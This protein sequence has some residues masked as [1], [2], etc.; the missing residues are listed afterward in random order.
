MVEGSFGACDTL[1]LRRLPAMLRRPPGAAFVERARRARVSEAIKVV[2]PPRL[3]LRLPVRFRLERD[4]EPVGPCRT[5]RR[6]PALVGHTSDIFTDH[7]DPWL[8]DVGER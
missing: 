1:D 3:R 8:P 6:L 7:T 2:S 5:G 4:A